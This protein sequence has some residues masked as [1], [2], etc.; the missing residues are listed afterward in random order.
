VPEAGT[1][2]FQS[3][4]VIASLQALAEQLGAHRGFFADV[5]VALE[6]EGYPAAQEATHKLLHAL[7]LVVSMT[8]RLH[9]NVV[10]IDELGEPVESL[11]ELALRARSMVVMARAGFIRELL[12]D[13]PA[14]ERAQAWLVGRDGSVGELMASI[15]DQ[16]RRI[17]RVWTP[18][19]RGGAGLGRSSDNDRTAFYHQSIRLAH[20]QLRSLGN[21]PGLAHFLARGVAAAD[22]AE[23]S[24]ACR[25]I[26]AALAVEVDADPSLLYGAPAPAPTS[27]T[28]LP[29]WTPE[30]TPTRKP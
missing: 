27:S 25:E 9:A 28:T 19:R 21:S 3:G 1:M 5:A 7:G 4:V 24:T 6:R 26:V 22:W 10:P 8:A 18:H 11:A 23:M 13:K 17:H 29:L 2:R 12:R 30:A 16:V 15:H 14:Q 20:R